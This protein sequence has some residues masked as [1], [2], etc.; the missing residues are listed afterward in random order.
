[1]LVQF[2]YGTALEL[3]ERSHTLSSMHTNLQL[4]SHSP[5]GSACDALEASHMLLS[6]QTYLRG[7]HCFSQSPLGTADGLVDGWQT[8]LLPHRYFDG[9]G[10]T[11]VELQCDSVTP[12]GQSVG[13]GQR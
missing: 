11:Q 10:G 12:P 9:G 2:V 8:P 4:F 7:K 1:M 3:F 13:S 6:A 5:M